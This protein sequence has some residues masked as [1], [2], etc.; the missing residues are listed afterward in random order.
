MVKC[1]TNADLVHNAGIG[2]ADAISAK[3][4]TPSCMKI[5][6]LVGY[7]NNGTDCL[8]VA[9]HLSNSGGNVTALLFTNRLSDEWIND[10]V[11]SGVDVIAISKVDNTR[12]YFRRLVSSTL[13]LI[14]AILGTGA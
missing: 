8:I 12:E 11:E 6:V 7:G 2:I 5:L 9:R 3:F 13:L 4:G 14:D 1:F 10:A